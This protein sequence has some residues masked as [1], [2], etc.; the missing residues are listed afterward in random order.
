[1]DLVDLPNLST[2]QRI[3]YVCLLVVSLASFLSI[4]EPDNPKPRNKKKANISQK[5]DLNQNWPMFLTFNSTTKRKKADTTV[6]EG[7]I[8]GETPASKISKD[9]IKQE[10]EKEPSSPKKLSRS[11]STETSSRKSENDD[12]REEML[13]LQELDRLQNQIKRESELRMIA[14][15]NLHLCQAQLKKEQETVQ[16]LRKKVIGLESKLYSNQPIAKIT[17][18]WSQQ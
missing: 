10:N 12:E 1:M 17:E 8:G 7:I 11:S 6:N 13:K 2:V 4:F 18:D 14:E 16:L 15:E 3:G 5:K 9:E